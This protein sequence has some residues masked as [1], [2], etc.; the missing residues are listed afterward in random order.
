MASTDARLFLLDRYEQV[1]RIRNHDDPTAQHPF[2]PI[3]MNECEDWAT[4]GA[5]YERM[6]EF[7]NKRIH[8]HFGISFL[9]FIDQPTYRC[10]Q[11]LRLA[12]A[13]QRKEKEV[14]DGLDNIERN[15]GAARGNTV[16][17]A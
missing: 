4:G 2:G 15:T 6:K 8:E 14:V 17:R 10:D 3:L 12:A 7:K 16:Q 9:E 1:F 11:M 13:A 5:V